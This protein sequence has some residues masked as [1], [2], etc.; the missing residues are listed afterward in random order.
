MTDLDHHLA[1]EQ[2]EQGDDGTHHVVLT[3]V[4]GHQF[5]SDGSGEPSDVADHAYDQLARHLGH[6]PR[7]LDEQHQ[8]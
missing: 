7:V 6:D 3:C 8:G 5:V 2:H 4:C 1:A